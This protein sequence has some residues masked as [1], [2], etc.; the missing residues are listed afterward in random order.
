MPKSMIRH[1]AIESLVLLIF[2]DVFVGPEPR[3]VTE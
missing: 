1:M 3:I 2:S